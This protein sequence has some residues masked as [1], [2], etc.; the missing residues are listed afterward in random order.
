MFVISLMCEEWTEKFFEYFEAHIHNFPEGPYK[1]EQNCDLKM[2][3]SCVFECE[4][5]CPRDNPLLASATQ[6]LLPQ[7]KTGL[8]TYS[9]VT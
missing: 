3:T 4:F 7:M 1:T 2:N 9:C 6:L 5:K 8:F